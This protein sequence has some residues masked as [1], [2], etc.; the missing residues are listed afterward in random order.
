MPQP[1][2][3]ALEHIMRLG[4]RHEQ[5]LIDQPGR[6]AASTELKRSLRELL[7]SLLVAPVAQRIEDIALFETNSGPLLYQHPLIPD[8]PTSGP[9]GV[10]QP[11]VQRAK[12]AAL[13]RQLGHHQRPAGIR[14]LVERLGV[15]KPGLVEH[16]EKAAVKPLPVAALK[17]GA[18][19]PLRRILGM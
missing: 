5:S 13:S 10:E 8:V 17:I 18:R 4:A 15:G 6:D 11:R 14:D 1:L 2:E 7:D 12:L 3:H 16:R 19:N 9:V